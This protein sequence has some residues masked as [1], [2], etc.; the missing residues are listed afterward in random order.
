MGKTQ[1]NFKKPALSEPNDDEHKHTFVPLSVEGADNYSIVTTESGQLFEAG[2]FH[3]NNSLGAYTKV[4]KLDDKVRLCKVAPT[5]CWVVLNNNKIFYKGISTDYHFPNNESSSSA[6]KEFKLWE[7]EEHKED[8]I[9]LAVGNPFTLFLTQKRKLWAVGEAFLTTLDASSQRPVTLNQ[10]LPQ[11]L[12]PLRIWASTSPS[13]R[14]AFVEVEDPASGQKTLLSAGASENGLLGQGNKKSSIKFKPLD[15]DASKTTFTQLCV[16]GDAALAI[17]QDFQLWGW[18]MNTSHRLG[19]TNIEESGISKPFKLYQLNLLG[20]KALQASLSEH[21]SLILFENMEGKQ[22]LYAAGIETAD[23]F[24]H[25]GCNEDQANDTETP[26]REVATLSQRRV[27]ALKAHDAPASLLIVAGDDELNKGLY[28]HSLPAG[29]VAHGLLH[30]YK[31][32]DEWKYVNH[33]DYQTKS[34]ELPQICF[35]IRCPISDIPSRE[36]PDLDKL[37]AEILDQ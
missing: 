14:V 36:W 26:F 25:L 8:V 17:D 12:T 3:G 11:G 4:S 21:H 32:G 9:G 28:N 23:N 1:T 18:G 29:K 22:V 27:L 7:N 24:A 30:F 6:F 15:Y 10:K 20:F 35:A 13:H 16:S 31:Q 37:A 5:S 33:E 2:D 19:L 34:K